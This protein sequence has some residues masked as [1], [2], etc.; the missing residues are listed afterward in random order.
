MHFYGPV[1]QWI[2]QFRPKEKVAGSTLAR[3]TIINALASLGFLFWYVARGEPIGEACH[4]GHAE[5]SLLGRPSIP[6]ECC[7]GSKNID[8]CPDHQK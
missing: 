1:A 3:I 8:S 4:T 2:E 5:F 7:R 6:Q